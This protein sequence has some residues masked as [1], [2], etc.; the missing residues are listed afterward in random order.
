MIGLVHVAIQFP[1]YE[2]FKVRLADRDGN[3]SLTGLVVATAT[4]KTIAGAISYPHEV[5]RSRQQHSTKR[6]RA[7]DAVR[8]VLK[9]SG[10]QGFYHGMGTNL[11]RVLP[12]CV[13]TF[14]TYEFVAS[15]LSDALAGSKLA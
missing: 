5:V 13:I 1:L 14:V 10:W 11:M 3:L 7:I 6:L 4:S 8:H 9:H 2:S 12:S 15:I